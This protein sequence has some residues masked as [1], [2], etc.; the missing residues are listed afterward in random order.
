MWKEAMVIY[1]EVISLY[2]PDGTKENHGEPQ[3]GYSV[4]QP[5]FE[6]STSRMKIKIFTA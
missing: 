3:S 4:F 2:L 5:R 6:P 1:L